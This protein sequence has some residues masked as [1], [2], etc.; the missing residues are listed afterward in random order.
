MFIVDYI[1]VTDTFILEPNRNEYSY[2]D[3]RDVR[4]HFRSIWWRYDKGKQAWPLA[5]KKI[6]EF[7]EWND[8]FG[9][10]SIF[11]NRAKQIIKSNPWYPEEIKFYRGT[12]FDESLLQNIKLY[13]Y[14]KEDISWMI[15]RNVCFNANDAGLGKTVE[16]IATLTYW[17]SKGF[18]DS[19]FIVVKNGLG[20]HWLREFCKY[21]T[22]FKEDDI[23]VIDNSSKHAIFEACHRKKIII[24]PNHLVGFALAY[25]RKN[26]KSNTLSK[27]RWKTYVDIHK[28]WKK[29]S[30]ALVI[31][32][33]HEFKNP[34]AV[35]SKALLHHRN[36]FSHKIFTTATAAINTFQDYWFQYHLLDPG[37]LPYC[38][39]A[40]M[41]KIAESIG[42]RYGVYNINK[43]EGGYN[44]RAIERIKNQLKFYTIKRLKKDTPEIKTKQMVKT[45]Y[46]SLSDKHRRIEE[47]IYNITDLS[48]DE[49]FEPNLTDEEYNKKM[50]Y[51]AYALMALENPMML[52]DVNREQT[53]A[54]RY[55]DLDPVLFTQLQRE[56]RSWKMD[57]DSRIEY[58]DTYLKEYIDGFKEK[59]I[60]FDIHPLTLEMLGER[61]QKYSPVIV[62]GQDGLSQNERWEKYDL[63]ND[64]SSKCKLMLASVYI[65][66][67]G[68]SFDK[69]GR[70]SIFYN[71]PQDATPYRQA[72]DRQYRASSREDSYVQILCLSK[73]LDEY[74]VVRCLTR[75]E[76][77]DEL[78]NANQKD[79]KRL[80][81]KML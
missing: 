59:V 1:D 2:D 14:Q 4:E 47:L 13:N 12:K 26:K 37:I 61:Y 20:F 56:L 30:L 68:Y 3:F 10:N 22:L 81:D 38:D 64:R 60:I 8:Y 39:K 28:V 25:Y 35:K 74:K 51:Y 48:R 27:I 75:T 9:W 49:Y 23:A 32:E 36:F 76:V 45:I 17:Y 43:D 34:K 46:F 65:A 44:E 53:L 19:V 6:F 41:I 67:V 72:L 42:D 16:S 50:S 80:V 29:K 11:S 66:G 73:T 54:H 18:I 71:V 15:A 5:G 57:D 24:I 78:F 70:R 52:A 7:L 62:H 58:I 63:F 77:N 55:P 21:G 33:S 79:T 31:D 69:G 40:F